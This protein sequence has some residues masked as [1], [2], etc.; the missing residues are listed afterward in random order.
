MIWTEMDVSEDTKKLLNELVARKKKLDRYAKLR[1]LLAYLALLGSTAT[2][3]YFYKAILI[4]SGGNIM[5]MLGAL[6][7]SSA[8]VLLVFLAAF[9]FYLMN[10]YSKKYDKQKAKYESLREEAVDHLRGP[11]IAARLT[12]D[13]DKISGFLQQTYKINVTYKS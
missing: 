11:S 13:K 1:A 9:L 2:V 6:A 7:G 4:P 12:D 3:V 10:Y 8:N 5:R